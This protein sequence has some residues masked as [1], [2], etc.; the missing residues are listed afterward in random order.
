MPTVPYGPLEGAEFHRVSTI[1]S[2]DDPLALRI[3]MG[4]DPEVGYYINFRGDPEKVREMIE[5]LAEVAKVMV[6]EGKYKDERTRPPH[7]A[8]RPIPPR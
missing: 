8:G 3:S 1:R 6:A 5:M 4:G 7:H 2:D